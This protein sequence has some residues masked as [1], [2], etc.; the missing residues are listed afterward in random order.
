MC[1]YGS[2]S[3]RQP[4]PATNENIIKYGR[5]STGAIAKSD[6]VVDNDIQR[7]QIALRNQLPE[8]REMIYKTK[9]G[10]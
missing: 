1:Y 6:N 3:T 9:L 5:S 7:R 2:S 8:N 4:V 10:A